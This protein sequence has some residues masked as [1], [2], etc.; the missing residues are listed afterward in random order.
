MTLIVV[1]SGLLVWLTWAR[2]DALRRR[3]EEMGYVRP[4]RI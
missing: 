4:V 2:G 1:L 3:R